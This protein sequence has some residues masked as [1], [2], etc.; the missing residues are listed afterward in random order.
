[1]LALGDKGPSLTGCA[2]VICCCWLLDSAVRFWHCPLPK[3]PPKLQPVDAVLVEDVDGELG[4]QS[5]CEQL[6]ELVSPEGVCVVVL[7]QQQQGQQEGQERASL[8]DVRAWL[9]GSRLEWVKEVR[10]RYS[11]GSSSGASLQTARAGIWLHP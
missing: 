11:S 8:E 2:A 10:F 4:L 7:G 3:L 1:M 9:S 6:P 5:V